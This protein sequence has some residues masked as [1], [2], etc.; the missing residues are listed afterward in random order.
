MQRHVAGKLLVER[1]Q[2]LQELLMP[3]A[4]IALADHFALQGFQGG[5]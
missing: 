3:V 2:E 5:E 1:A 4:R